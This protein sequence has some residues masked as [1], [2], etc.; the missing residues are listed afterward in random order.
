MTIPYRGQIGDGIYFI[1]ASTWEQQALLQSDRMARLFI[2]VL[3]HYRNQNKYLLHEFDSHARSFS[4]TGAPIP[5]V[6]LEKAVQFIKGGFSF[7][8][9]TE[10]A[11]IGEIWQT[12]FYERRVRTLVS[13]NG[14]ST[15]YIRIQ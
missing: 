10:L 4:S 3:F 5:P 12:S 6:T 1:T 8:A 7:R 11:V 15:T 2:E 13:M 14:S 9:K